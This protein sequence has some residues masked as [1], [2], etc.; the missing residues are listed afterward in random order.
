MFV[1]KAKIRPYSYGNGHK[2]IFC[3][4]VQILNTGQERVVGQ[5]EKRC[6]AYY[7]QGEKISAKELKKKIMEH[8]LS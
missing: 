3:D 4:C 7:L 8:E 6:G 1:C 5:V 2:S